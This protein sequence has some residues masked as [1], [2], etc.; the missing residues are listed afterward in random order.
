MQN[1]FVI[2]ILE[3]PPAKLNPTGPI[4]NV[5]PVNLIL[6]IKHF[7]YIIHP[8][9]ITLTGFFWLSGQEPKGI[10]FFRKEYNNI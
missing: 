2:F 6:L 4:F 9:F 1:N 7:L 3:R 5:I 8:S 10:W